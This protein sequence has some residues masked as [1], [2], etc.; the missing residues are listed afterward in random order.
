LREDELLCRVNNSTS[1]EREREREER[2][3]RWSKRGREREGW[4]SIV[5]VASFGGGN[6]SLKFWKLSTDK[7]ETRR[8]M[9]ATLYCKRERV[10]NITYTRRTFQIFHI[11]I[12]YTQERMFCNLHPLFR[13]LHTEHNFQLWQLVVEIKI[14]IFFLV[15]TSHAAIHVL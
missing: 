8:R 6:I 4:K 9:E 15:P 13:A 7:G 10:Q 2:G 3:W 14:F 11:Y 12:K 5:Y 1:R